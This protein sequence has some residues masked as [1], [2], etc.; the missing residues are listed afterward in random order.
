MKVRINSRYTVVNGWLVDH[1]SRKIINPSFR[2]LIR[3]SL[4]DRNCIR[5]EE[6]C[7]WNE[8]LASEN[9]IVPT[10]DA[11]LFELLS[12]DEYVFAERRDGSVVLSTATLK[13]RKPKSVVKLLQRRVIE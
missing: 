2:N 3:L 9:L 8:V 13:R 1:N 7:N 4:K 11:E 12:V 6:L 5:D 10:S